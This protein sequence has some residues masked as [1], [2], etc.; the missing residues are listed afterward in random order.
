MLA[1]K[2]CGKISMA[3]SFSDSL[4]SKPLLTLRI[5]PALSH[6]L[7]CYA[8]G[9]PI[10]ALLVKQHVADAMKPGDHGS[11]FAGSPLV[12][13]AALTVLDIISQQSF[14]EEVVSKG[15]RLREG[16]R[17]SLGSNSHVQEIR[18]LGL[19]TGIQLDT[20]SL[21]LQK[22][23]RSLPLQRYLPRVIDPKPRSRM[24]P[25]LRKASSEDTVPEKWSLGLPAL[26]AR[27]EKA[28][29]AGL[30]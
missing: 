1:C 16:L 4:P 22:T 23:I 27:F 18:G 5:Y 30:S 29:S 28:Y 25:G 26:Y 24:A 6:K 3:N 15:E 14:L 13:H 19:I 12:C 20:V 2:L 8:G 9:L 10:G 11:T 21:L 17:K 7:C